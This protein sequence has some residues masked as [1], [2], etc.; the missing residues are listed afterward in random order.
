MGYRRV[1]GGFRRMPKPPQISAVTH[2][3]SHGNHETFKVTR[4]LRPQISLGILVPQILMCYQQ[5]L[6]PSNLR[7]ITQQAVR[8]EDNMKL[9]NLQ[10]KPQTLVPPPQHTPVT[11]STPQLMH[12][13][14][15]V[16]PFYPH[17]PY[18]PF[19]S[20]AAPYPYN[21]SSHSHAPAPTRVPLAIMPA[22]MMQIKRTRTE[23]QSLYTSFF[24]SIIFHQGNCDDST[25]SAKKAKIAR[26]C[27]F[28]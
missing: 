2:Q 15:Y 12:P 17:Y 9:E 22:N 18:P 4:D 16:Q 20:F 24:E 7:E 25:A 5:T 6:R 13:D 8:E 28:I 3:I 21:A 27:A 26:K 11:Y 23:V 19:P 1:C 14:P 10:S